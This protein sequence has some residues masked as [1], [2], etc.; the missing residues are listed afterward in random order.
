M[1]FAASQSIPSIIFRAIGRELGAKDAIFRPWVKNA[2]IISH[3]SGARVRETGVVL[4][5]LGLDFGSAAGVVSV[6]CW[7]FG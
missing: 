1:H 4:G 2:F 6:M 3:Q 5:G 7:A